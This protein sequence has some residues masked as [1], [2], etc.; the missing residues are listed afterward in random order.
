VLWPNKRKSDN[1]LA[2][3]GSRNKGINKSNSRLVNE[4]ETLS[5]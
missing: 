3:K 2:N 4:G 1:S 5:S